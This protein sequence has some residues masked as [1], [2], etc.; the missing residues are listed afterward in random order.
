MHSKS[1]SFYDR[2][3]ITMRDEGNLLTTR[4]YKENWQRALKKIKQQILIKRLENIR[5]SNPFSITDELLA[6]F[7]RQSELAGISIPKK[8]PFLIIHPHHKF[9]LVWLIIL[10]LSLLYITTYGAYNIAFEDHYINSRSSKIEVLVDFIVLFDLILTMNL[11]YFND[12][13]IL[14]TDR[15]LI[16]RKFFRL[17]NLFDLFAAVPVWIIC[18][19]N[20]MKNLPQIFYLRFVPKLIQL[21]RLFKKIK[22]FLFLKSVDSFII[23]NKEIVHFVKIFGMV[24]LCLHLVSCIFYVSA[25]IDDFNP[26]TWV[27]RNGLKNAEAS[28]KYLASIYWAITTLATIGYGDITPYTA[29]EKATGMIW[30]IIGVYIV[31]YT[32][33]QFTS[34]YS[35]LSDKDTKITEELLLVEELAKFTYI[36]N[37]E[38]KKIKLCIKRSSITLST[39]KI[40][41]ILNEI[42]SDLRYEIAKNIYKD[43]IQKFPFFMSKDKNFINYIVFKLEY[44]ETTSEKTLWVP[45]EFS[46][47]IYFIIEGRIKFLHKKMLF[48]VTNSG[49]YIG[50]IEIF[51]KTPRKFTVETCEHCKLFKI[52]QEWLMYI[53]TNFTKYYI[54]MKKSIGKRCR[55]QMINLAEMVAIRNY[56]R[57]RIDKISKDYIKELQTRLH[58][59]FYDFTKEENKF[60]N[61]YKFQ[62]QLD[63]TDRALKHTM[64]LFRNV[65][66]FLEWNSK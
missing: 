13:N 53:K 6:H 48:I 27:S 21:V 36:P 63:L 16:L 38:K 55:N 49:Q 34:F 41:K 57:G 37:K 43:A 52:N 33:G 65:K 54:E 50:D 9:Y 3:D 30:M 7:C 11:A 19:C 12:D 28:D 10:S 8:F 58:K 2:G 61:L 24:A 51:L 20:K 23:R 64:N 15:K 66:I 60:A 47:G 42:P 26:D 4:S 40:E 1:I 35:S 62:S 46:E 39:C 5:S 44:I 22:N 14:I 45:E 29:I 25:R 32:V 59:K 31:S 17:N 18:L 56:Y